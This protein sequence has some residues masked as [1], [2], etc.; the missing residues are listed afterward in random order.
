[1]STVLYS[2]VDTVE[3]VSYKKFKLSNKT[4]AVWKRF[5]RFEDQVGTY[6][7]CT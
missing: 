6:E 4:R 7:G 1:M 2:Y 3:G 5:M